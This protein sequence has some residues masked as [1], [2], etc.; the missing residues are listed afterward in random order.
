[1]TASALAPAKVNLYLHVGPPGADG[2]HPLQTLMV[3][4][5]IGDEVSLAAKA[6]PAL[7]ISGAFAPDLAD[8]DN[9]VTRAAALL[10]ARTGRGGEGTSI[11]L[12]KRLPVAAGLGGGSADAAAALRLLAQANDLASDDP[13]LI[14]AARATGADVP[15]CLGARARMMRG[16]GETLGPPLRLPLLPA[17]LINP[18]VP[19]ETKPVFQS[20]GLRPGESSGFGAHLDI[21]P[22]LCF[23]DLID[24]LE[25]C[26]NDLE[27][28][29]C[30]QA[31]AIVDVLAVLR[32]AR[33]C[34]LARMSGSG[35][36]CFAI[37][38]TPRGAAKAAH[39]IRRQHPGW[40]VK[41]AA[42]Q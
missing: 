7:E 28:P 25:H 24:R 30:L 38:A 39:A 11:R 41:T 32:A 17:V 21:P 8:G 14:E 20:L 18:G 42:L 12:D 13:R 10:A 33:G 29:A 27:D 19:V 16:A 22:G 40:W 35:A 31:P 26:R 6:G 5:D 34:R 37:F 23:A 1:M 36:T 9:L 4:A 2:F 15:V 3:F